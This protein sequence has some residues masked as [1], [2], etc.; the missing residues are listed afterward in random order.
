MTDLGNNIISI[1]DRT[2]NITLETIGGEYGPEL[3]ISDSDIEFF[4]TLE[5]ILDATG[6]EISG[7][8]G[9]HTDLFEDFENNKTTKIKLS[10]KKEEKLKGLITNELLMNEEKE[11]YKERFS[12]YFKSKP[13]KSIYLNE[14]ERE[15]LK[16]S[17]KKIRR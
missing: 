7:Y 13:G 5:R 17:L 2:N 14:D 1:F 4:P 8:D 10:R 12:D 16:K 15:I 3:M 11:L 9:G 6:N